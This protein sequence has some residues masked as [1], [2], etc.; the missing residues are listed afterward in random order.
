MRLYRKGEGK[1][2]KLLHY[3]FAY[4]I[5]QVI[6]SIKYSVYSIIHVL[7]L[8]SKHI[9]IVLHYDARIDGRCSACWGYC[10]VLR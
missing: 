2:K 3:A 8:K 7:S 6:V 10:D 9:F 1:Q 4:E 5:F